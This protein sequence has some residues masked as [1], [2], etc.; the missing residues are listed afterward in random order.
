MATTHLRNLRQITRPILT[1]T[2][3][4]F[5]SIKTKMFLQLNKFWDMVETESKEPD[6]NALAAMSNA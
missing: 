5:W 2:N 1:D 6:T 3:Y 4:E